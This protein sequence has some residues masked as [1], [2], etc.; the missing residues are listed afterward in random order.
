MASQ[1]RIA[2]ALGD[3]D[4]LDIGLR[5]SGRDENGFA[6]VNKPVQGVEVLAGVCILV[7]DAHN[8]TVDDADA[9]AAR[10]GHDGRADGAGSSRRKASRP[11]G[12]L[13]VEDA[14]ILITVLRAGVSAGACEVRWGGLTQR[15]RAA[16]WAAFCG[17]IGK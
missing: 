1:L 7:R 5:T 3:V 14:L 10:C 15:R 2:G 8:I 17:G 11:E 16:S 4:E 6:A 13:V 9:L 12:G